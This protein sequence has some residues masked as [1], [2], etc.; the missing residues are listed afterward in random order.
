M[1]SDL[2]NARLKANHNQMQAAV[3]IG[4]SQN[5]II[6]VEKDDK[7]PS[8]RILTEAIQKYINKWSKK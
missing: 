6:N 4:V 8:S 5:L 1:S 3:A 2:K 7:W